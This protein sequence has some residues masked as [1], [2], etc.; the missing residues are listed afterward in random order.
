M[1]ETNTFAAEKNDTMDSVSLTRG[2]A[3]LSGLH[4]KSFIGGFRE[5]TEK[6]EIELV[7]GVAIGFSNGGMIGRAVFESCQ[8]EIIDSL[9]AMGRLDGVYFSLHGAMVAEAP[10]TDAEGVV[11]RE[12]RELLGTSLSMV[13]TYD[14]HSI[15]SRW[16]N[17]Q[18]AVPFP[19]DTNPHIDAYEQ[20]LE[21]AR[22]MVNMLNGTWKPITRRLFV[23]II[24]VCSIKHPEPQGSASAVACALTCAGVLARTQ[25]RPEHVVA[26][27]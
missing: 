23:P 4:P 12:A 13:A 10:Y 11:I 17:E 9:K 8:K 22:C 5:V 2:E 25:H 7:P 24:G 3:M 20:G 21:A 27:P 18:G 14:F 26:D 15:A 6:S 16:E 19:H 1:H